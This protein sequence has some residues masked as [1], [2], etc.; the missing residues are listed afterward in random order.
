EHEHVPQAISQAL[1]TLSK[2]GDPAGWPAAKAHLHSPHDGIAAVAWRTA[3]ALAPE[4]ARPGLAADLAEELGRGG[5]ELQRSLARAL[6][7]LDEL[8]VIP[9]ELAVSDTDEDRA[10][11][12]RA[13]LRVVHDPGAT[14][15][16]D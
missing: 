3:T 10:R 5:F 7:E 14:F 13:A 4:V 6:S 9:L 1:H 11:H 2:L 12:A 16:L 8:A 15:Y